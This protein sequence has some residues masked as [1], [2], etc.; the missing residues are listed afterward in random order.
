MWFVLSCKPSLLRSTCPM[1]Q[2]PYFA[3]S[4]PPPNPHT[5]SSEYYI[6]GD[7]LI[8]NRPTLILP[9]RCIKT[10]AEG[11]NL[12]RVDKTLYY[13]HPAWYLTLLINLLVLIIVYLVCRKPCSIQYSIDKSTA[14]KH[15]LLSGLS[16]LLF[17]AG[18][19]GFISGFVMT[20]TQG[21]VGIAVL[22]VS[23]VVLIASLVFNSKNMPVRITKYSNGQFHFKGFSKEYL[24]SLAADQ[25][26]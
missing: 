25:N 16:V 10:N 17:F 3:S 9:N 11:P 7:T 14:N 2:S 18:L 20:E 4:T 19:F 15:A 23:F 8:C 26:T 5:E 12:K 6:S 22:V 13:M 21:L 1:D 24:S